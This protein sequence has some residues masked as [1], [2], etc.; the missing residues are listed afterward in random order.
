MA[1]SNP[2]LPWHVIWNPNTPAILAYPGPTADND[3]GDDNSSAWESASATS[4]PDHEATATA[5]I[6]PHLASTTS[7]AASTPAS[8]I[9]SPPA[10]RMDREAFEDHL[11]TLRTAYTGD[12][13]ATQALSLIADSISQ[14]V[15]PP[16]ALLNALVAYDD[17]AGHY[18]C[19]IRSC[20]SHRRGHGW[21]RLDRARDHFR[22][23]HLKAYYLCPECDTRFRRRQDLRT[24]IRVHRGLSARPRCDQCRRG[25]ANTSNLNRHLERGHGLRP[26]RRTRQTS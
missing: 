6:A 26:H 11:P 16:N 8:A 23:E 13:V 17:R 24:H 20:P 18:H 12:A 10:L 19:V 9:S 4:L 2:A 5:T 1:D 15:N 3:L 22:T 21:A 25:F 7:P 14:G